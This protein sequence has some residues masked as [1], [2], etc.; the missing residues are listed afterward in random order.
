[1]QIRLNCAT[2]S[3]DGWNPECG[4]APTQFA[5]Y[6]AVLKKDVA[7]FSEILVPTHQTTPTA[8]VF[9]DFTVVF[10]D[11]TVVFIDFT[12][13]FIDFTVV[14]AFR[15][16]IAVV[17]IQYKIIKCVNTLRTGDGDLRF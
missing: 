2:G 8:V 16:V 17:F 4:A 1:M 7:H 9:I 11:F 12:V 14:L 5:R 13:V 3:G 6:V 15:S 10:I